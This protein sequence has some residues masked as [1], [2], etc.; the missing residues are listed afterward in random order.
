MFTELLE[1]AV[2]A[3][4]CD[5]STLNSILSSHAEPSPVEF[6]QAGSQSNDKSAK[7]LLTLIIF[8]QKLTMNPLSQSSWYVLHNIYDIIHPLGLSSRTDRN[9]LIT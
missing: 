8:A 9:A 1:Y 7:T 3:G 2:T 5:Q 4:H 6:T